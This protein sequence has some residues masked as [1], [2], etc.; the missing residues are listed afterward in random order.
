MSQSYQYIKK[1]TCDNYRASAAARHHRAPQIGHYVLPPNTTGSGG[2]ELPAANEEVTRLREEVGTLRQELSVA[3]ETLQIM[4]E[5]LQA[6]HDALSA[7]ASEA[8]GAAP[9]PPEETHELDC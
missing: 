8:S 2:A 1:M 7:A 3:I 4:Q 9:K 5:E 6:A